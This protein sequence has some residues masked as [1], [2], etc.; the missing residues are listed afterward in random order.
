ML[1][2]NRR[3]GFRILSKGNKKKVAQSKKA[4]EHISKLR[5]RIFNT[6]ES[7]KLVSKKLGKSS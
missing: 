7:S 3:K 4:L 5:I 2:R 6:Q 1:E